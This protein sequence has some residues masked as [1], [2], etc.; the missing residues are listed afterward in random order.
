MADC[1]GSGGLCNRGRGK[2]G[3]DISRSHIDWKLCWAFG[4]HIAFK[5]VGTTI[6]EH[7]SRRTGRPSVC[8]VVSVSI[9]K[10]GNFNSGYSQ[11]LVGL[12]FL[13]CQ[14]LRMVK[15][16][17]VSQNNMQRNKNKNRGANLK[18]T[19]EQGD[20]VLQCSF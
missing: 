4:Q 13:F 16:Q 5:G 20:F 3:G 15:S 2:G 7:E 17:H 18:S 14:F 12:A 1:S 19:L 6:G 10:L 11:D 9:A 8:C